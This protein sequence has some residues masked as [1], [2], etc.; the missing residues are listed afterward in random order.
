MGVIASTSCGEDAQGVR[1]DVL[2][3]GEIVRARLVERFDRARGEGDLPPHA[4]SDAMTSFL[5][6]LV[7]GISLQARA[8]AS[9][10]QLKGLIKV[11]LGSWSAYRSCGC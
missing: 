9:R 2:K 1:D 5:F 6:A 3:R 7:P 10:E 4:D 11:G 8:G